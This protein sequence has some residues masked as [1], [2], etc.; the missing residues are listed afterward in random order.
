MAV[1]KRTLAQ[2]G[3]VLLVLP[4]AAFALSSGGAELLHQLGFTT[5]VKERSA[6]IFFVVHA[7]V[8]TVALVA[9]PLQWILARSA[10]TLRIHR[11]V[12]RA[13]AVGVLIGALTAVRMAV[14]FDVPVAARLS[15]ATLAAVWAA[16]TG[17]GLR[18]ILAGA[19][20]SHRAW[21]TR[22]YALTLFFLTLLPRA[23]PRA[24]SGGTTS[25]TPSLCRSPGW[26]TW[27]SRRSGFDCNRARPY[28]VGHPGPTPVPA[29]R[30]GSPR[31]P[32]PLES[33]SCRE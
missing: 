26:S 5:D 28:L 19:V 13:Y 12:G 23:W 32:S 3:P 17:M 16:A 10:R 2:W 1:K 18:R 4:Y 22:S 33:P 6:P 25:R 31:E 11:L 20:T 14:T 7:V 8:G 30:R 15:F 24:A 27:R 9:G 21:M 29:A